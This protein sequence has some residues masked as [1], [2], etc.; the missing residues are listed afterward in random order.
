L[1]KEWSQHEGKRDENQNSD[2]LLLN[3]SV[4]MEDGKGLFSVQLSLVLKLAPKHKSAT[5]DISV[6]DTQPL[7][8]DKVHERNKPGPWSCDWLAKQ[9]TIADGG[10]VISS[11]HGTQQLLE[12]EADSLTAAPAFS[13]QQNKKKAKVAEDSGTQQLSE[14]R[15]V[16][17][18][19]KQACSKHNN[20]K[21]AE[22]VEDRGTQ[23]LLEAEVAPLP[24]GLDFS[25]QKNKKKGHVQRSVGFMKII[26]RMSDK[27]RKH[28]L[29]KQK[30]KMKESFI[31][32]NSKAADG[33]ISDSSK[34]YVSSV[35]NDWEHWVQLHGKAEVDV[36]ELG[37]VV[38]VDHQ[39]DTLN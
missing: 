39:C 23:Q 31:N 5:V 20:K 2:D 13:K 4:R 38:G 18:T 29:K 9:W 35:N 7:Q 25:K 1:H 26:T 37:K 27:D 30:C 24:T 6:G 22:D 12:A 32:N 10:V 21:K 3:N 19:S 28:I 14:T 33:S 17:L 15:V 36:K 34:H 11:N 16:S 8:V